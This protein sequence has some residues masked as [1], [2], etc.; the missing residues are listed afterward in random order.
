MKII[1]CIDDTDDLTKETSTGAIAQKIAT[2]LQ[3][4]GGKLIDG[5]SRHQLLLH[6]E[7]D[8]TS[9]NSSMCLFMDSIQCDFDEIR[10]CAEK[11]IKKHMAK[12]S[13]RACH[14]LY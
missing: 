9:H 7:I 6:E 1:L 10:D 8:Y 4:K 2:K 12:T 14:L 5:I 13:N 11:T 3:E